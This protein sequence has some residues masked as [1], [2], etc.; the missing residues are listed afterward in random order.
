MIVRVDGDAKQSI[1]NLLLAVL[2][3]LRRNHTHDSDRDESRDKAEVK[4]KHHSFGQ[5]AA[6][7][8]QVRLGIVIELVAAALGRVNDGA[9]RAFLGVELMREWVRSDIRSSSIVQ[10]AQSS[11]SCVRTERAM[12]GPLPFRAIGLVLSVQN[13]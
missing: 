5:K 1:I 6:Q 11:V 3:L 12:W 4:R 8:E 13:P 9:A 2:N 10:P 7:H